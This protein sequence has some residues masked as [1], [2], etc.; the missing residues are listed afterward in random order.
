MSRRIVNIEIHFIG[1]CRKKRCI[2]K[3]IVDITGV[4]C[5]VGKGVVGNQVIRCVIWST[6]RPFH[7]DLLVLFKTETSE[8]KLDGP[9]RCN[10]CRRR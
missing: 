1:F 10:V 6:H 8:S 9:D 7:D 4:R 3:H 5:S 2:D